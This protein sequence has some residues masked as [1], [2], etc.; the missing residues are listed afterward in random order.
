MQK[1]KIQY[2]EPQILNNMAKCAKRK[3][4]KQTEFEWQKTKTGRRADDI[5]YQEVL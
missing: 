5:S 2:K 4:L 1:I 3:K